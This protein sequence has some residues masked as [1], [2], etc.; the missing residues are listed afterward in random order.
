MI[1]T[2]I[3][4]RLTFIHEYNKTTAVLQFLNIVATEKVFSGNLE[5]LDKQ[6]TLKEINFQSLDY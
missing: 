2:G 1:L 3:K 5:S 4:A 6:S